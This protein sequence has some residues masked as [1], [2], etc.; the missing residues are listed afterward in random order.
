[1]RTLPL[2]TD[3]DLVFEIGTYL[4]GHGK[5]MPVSI[6][7]A[8]AVLRERLPGAVPKKELE[9]LLVEMCATRGLAVIFD[10][11]ELTGR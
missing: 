9:R 7:G 6:V 3:A 2:S 5:S 8:K 11:R 1:V 4:D 10:E